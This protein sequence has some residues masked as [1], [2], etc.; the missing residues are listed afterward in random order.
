MIIMDGCCTCISIHAPRTGSDPTL[1]FRP[2]HGGYFNPRSPHGERPPPLLKSLIRVWSFQSTLPARGATADGIPVRTHDLL[3]SI[4]A[5]RTGSDRISAAEAAIELFQST[6]P[7]RGATWDDISEAYSAYISIHAPRTGSDSTLTVQMPLS[8]YFNPRSP[9]GERQWGRWWLMLSPAHF[10]PRSPHGERLIGA[11]ASAGSI[12]NFNPR[13]PHGER[14]TMSDFKALSGD[15][16]PR[17]PHG[18]RLRRLHV[19]DEPAGFQ[20]TLPARGATLRLFLLRICVIYFNPRSPH[21]ERLVRRLSPNKI[22][23]HFNPRSPHGERRK[24]RARYTA[25]RNFNPRSPHG[26]RLSPSSR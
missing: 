14:P 18:E 1:S 5:P 9:H 17:S 6:L 20:S 12:R 2:R 16:N 3:I 15:F 13:S 21:G 22:I 23:A 26:E 19:S 24:E 10:N 7:A 8:S 11:C 4:H 25:L